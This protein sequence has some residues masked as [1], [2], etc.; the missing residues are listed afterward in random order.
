MHH[1]SDLCCVTIGIV[2]NYC[3]NTWPISKLGM[4]NSIVA[5]KKYSS[6]YSTLQVY[7]VPFGEGKGIM[8][9]NFVFNYLIISN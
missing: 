9:M 6:P 5:L 2:I 4:D 1:Q 8:L 3:N 7:P